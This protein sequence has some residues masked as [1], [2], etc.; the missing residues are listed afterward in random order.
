MTREQEQSV[1]AEILS[2]DS[3]KYELLVKEN[4]KRIY[5]LALRMTGSTEDAFDL[6][7]ES[8]LK[9]YYRLES[10]DGESG[11]ATWVYKIASNTC[12]DFIRKEK[13]RRGMNVISIDDDSDDRPLQLPDTRYT[14]ETELE[15]KELRESISA[16]L[17]ELPPE[18]REALIMREVS[19][20]SYE[21]IGNILEIPAG[22][23]KSRI[24][25]GRKRLAEILTRDGNFLGHK[26]S[27]KRKGGVSRE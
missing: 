21:E 3:D 2:G 7:Q 14:P 25:R 26:S 6:A 10:F 18:Y 20:M 1:I 12:I 13:K 27:N 23:V 5:N 24:A 22:T 19:G 16:G 9:A 15:K 4:E 11:F 17:L 8:F